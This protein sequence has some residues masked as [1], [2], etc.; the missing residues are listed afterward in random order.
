[1]ALTSSD[2]RREQVHQPDTSAAAVPRLQWTPLD[3]GTWEQPLDLGGYVL[4]LVVRSS[5][6]GH[7][8]VAERRHNLAASPSEV[9]REESLDLAGDASDEAENATDDG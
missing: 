1:V 5:A 8:P 6:S 7:D 9:E 2:A 4:D 3:R